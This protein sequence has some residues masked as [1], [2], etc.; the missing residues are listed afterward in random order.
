MGWGGFGTRRLADDSPS[1]ST[2]IS[3]ES[4]PMSLEPLAPDTAVEQYLKSREQDATDSTVR[5]HRY[6][7]RQFLQWAEETGLDNMNE[8]TGR[9]AERFKNWRISERDINSVTL[10]QHLRTFRVFVRWCESVDA[11]EQGTADKII[12]PRVSQGE[13]VREEHVDNEQADAIIDYLHRF[14]YAS[15]SQV[16]FHTLWH[17]GCRRGALHALDLDDWHPQDRYLAFRH[18]PETD[19]PLKLKDDGE[20]HVTVSDDRLA[21]S[22]DDYIAEN[23]HDVTD[24]HG[25]KPLFTTRNG[26]ISGNSI[27]QHVYKVTRPCFYAGECPHNREIDDCEGTQASGYSSCPSSLS[28]HPVRRGAITA[29]LNNDIPKEIASERMSVSVDTLEEHYDA[30]TAEE[31]RQN[32]AQYLDNL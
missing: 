14:E 18:R 22:L 28:P 10:E 21:Q 13:K 16:L 20:R 32:R 6:R 17:T 26:R 8:L 30:R 25:R 4:P 31:K 11:V 12:V 19:T 5:N 23:R 29:H 2:R 24:E 7:L 9:L 3:S 1:V 27:Q 15:R